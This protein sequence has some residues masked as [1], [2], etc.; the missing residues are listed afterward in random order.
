MTFTFT[1][2]ANRAFR[3]LSDDA[4]RGADLNDRVTMALGVEGGDAS[5]TINQ[6]M[7]E[8]LK[9]WG[10]DGM[11]LR[12]FRF[13]AP[14]ASEGSSV[15]H[16]GM[17]HDLAND[18]FNSQEVQKEIQVSVGGGRTS[19]LSSVLAASGE[20]GRLSSDV[21]TLDCTCTSLSILNRLL[22][23]KE[24][25]RNPPP[26]PNPEEPSATDV[27]KEY[28]YPL[29]RQM[30]IFLPGGVTVSDALREY[31]MLS[32]DTYSENRVRMLDEDL[33]GSGAAPAEE[34]GPDA[35]LSDGRSFPLIAPAHRKEFLFHVF[36]RLVSGGSPMCQ[37]EENGIFYKLG[38]REFYKDLV[39][40]GRRRAVDKT[41]R[42]EVVVQSHVLAVSAVRT[43]RGQQ[44]RIF[45]VSDEMSP[46]NINFAY[47]V[48]NPSRR[49]VVWWYNAFNSF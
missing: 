20:V 15:F 38:A 23:S 4:A 25:T 11:V 8:L 16:Q 26:M 42:P 35:D 1:L 43:G 19:S 7:P 32:D 48:V 28:K 49:E 39:S 29:I 37:F 27:N 40:A 30:D 14:S 24:I 9:K 47:L 13:E 45:P 10:F 3:C 41:S 46:S 22:H 12:S 36:W 17:L 18:F 21:E 5:S 44:L 34:N 2:N 31:I 33:A 6:M